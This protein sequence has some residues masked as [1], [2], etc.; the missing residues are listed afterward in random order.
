VLQHDAGLMT[1]DPQQQTAGDVNASGSPTALD[2]SYILQYA[3]GLIGL[4]F[5][6]AGA[7]W[8]FD[9]VNRSYAPLNSNQTGQDFAGILI[10]DPTGNWGSAGGE[11]LDGTGTLFL[12][13]VEGC[14]GSAPI[15]LDLWDLEPGTDVYSVE[16]TI[17]FNPAIISLIDIE[18]GTLALGWSVIVNDLVPG[19][20]RVAMAGANPIAAAGELLTLTV[21]PLAD[22]SS[23]LQVD[24]AQLNEGLIATQSTSGAVINCALFAD[25]F[26]DGT[27]GAW[28]SP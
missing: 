12:P 4:P 18:A 14:G 7:I 27:M 1:L 3:V 21:V 24:R 6:G 28:Y 8:A 26:E 13:R 16:L 15:S 20:L 17:H 19:E 5:P 23:P 22:G 11:S 10:G 2:A 9:P 25:G